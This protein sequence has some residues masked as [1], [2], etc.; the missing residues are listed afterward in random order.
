MSSLAQR[1]RRYVT[2]YLELGSHG[3][4]T[5]LEDA[6]SYC[7]DRPIL[8]AQVTSEI[9][10]F[11]KLL[12]AFSPRRSLEI[13]T[14]YGGTLFLLCTL[15]PPDAKIISVDLPNG[16]FGGGYPLRKIPLFRRFPKRGQSLHLIRGDSHA[17]ET[18][19]RV[20]KI[21]RGELLDYVFIDADHTYEG[22]ECDF[23][24]YSTLVR[25]GGMVAFHDIETYRVQ[26][27]CEVSRFWNSVKHRYN[28]LE[29]VEGLNENALP[30]AVTGA[31][32]E[33]SGIGVLFMP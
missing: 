21:L 17:N 18:L 27:H 24:M 22:V 9:L 32:M 29:F 19:Q 14:N 20:K 7:I 25:S 31:P 2:C 12:R 33:T 15:S 8:L 1:I 5:K 3:R 10:E 30:T 23:R 6:V 28:H 4:P 26:S 16:Q 11:G 13:G